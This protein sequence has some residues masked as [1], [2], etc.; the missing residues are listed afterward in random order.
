MKW[1][2][3][4]VMSSTGPEGRFVQVPLLCMDSFRIVYY[5]I[6][7]STI[8]RVAQRPLDT[9]PVVSSGFCATIYILCSYVTRGCNFV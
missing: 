9:L 1:T 4:E 6:A 2:D 5:R 8:Y 7:S 3:T